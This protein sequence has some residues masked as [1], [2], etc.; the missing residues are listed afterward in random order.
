MKIIDLRDIIDN[1]ETEPD[2]YEA[3]KKALWDDAGYVIDGYPFKVGHLAL[4]I[5]YHEDL[6][7]LPRLG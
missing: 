6:R 7:A 2:T 4:S 1:Q 3:W 5:I